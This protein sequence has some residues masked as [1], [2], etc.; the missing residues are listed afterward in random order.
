MGDEAK[1][2]EDE[3]KTGNP[4]KAEKPRDG[5]RKETQEEDGRGRQRKEKEARRSSQVQREGRGWKRLRQ[6]QGRPPPG[7]GQTG[8]GWVWRPLRGASAV[9]A[10]E[11]VRT[12]E[13]VWVTERVPLGPDRYGKRPRGWAPFLALLGPHTQR[14]VLYS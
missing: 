5:G 8:V 13:R 4:I 1:T 7:T 10:C 9:R 6:G 14:P 2:V 12:C 3:T 11:W